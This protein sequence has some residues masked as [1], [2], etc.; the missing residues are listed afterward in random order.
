MRAPYIFLIALLTASQADAAKPGIVARVRTRMAAAKQQRQITS[1]I[2]AAIRADPSLTVYNKYQLERNLP[3]EFVI[4][5]TL[6]A[7]AAAIKVTGYSPAGVWAGM[8]TLAASLYVVVTYAADVARH[9]T[10]QHA[11][12]VG[13]P[14]RVDGAIVTSRNGEF[15][16]SSPDR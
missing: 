2:S 1:R 3:L 8:V 11:E 10:V 16:F 5:S 15:I 7:G 12:Q 6:V 14:L 9:D 13:R 4:T